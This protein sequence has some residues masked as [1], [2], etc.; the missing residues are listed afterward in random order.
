MQTVRENLNNTTGTLKKTVKRDT[1]RQAVDGSGGAPGGTVLVGD[2]SG[3]FG[4]GAGGTISVLRIQ[5]G[6]YGRL[7]GG[8]M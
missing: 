2:Y 1:S 7:P 4:Q 8:E 6:K 3:Y 5:Q